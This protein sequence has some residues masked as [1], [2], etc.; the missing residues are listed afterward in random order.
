MNKIENAE[1]G[2]LNWPLWLAVFNVLGVLILCVMPWA[3]N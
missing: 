3:N 2:S 1:W